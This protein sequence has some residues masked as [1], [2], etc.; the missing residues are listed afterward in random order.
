MTKPAREHYEQAL[1]QCPEVDAEKAPAIAKMRGAILF[2]LAELLTQQGQ[3]Q[4]AMDLYQQS[5]KIDEQIGNVKGKAATLANMAWL[6]WQQGDHEKAR[7]LNLQAAKAFAS[8]RAWLNLVT[9]LGNLGHTGASDAS[10]FLAQA[11][12]L[13]MRVEIPLDEALSLAA[14]LIE[15]LGPGADAV[16]SIAIAGIF[17][18][19][20]R[21][22]DHPQHEEIQEQAL[23]L[24]AACAVVPV[25]S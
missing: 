18:V 20:T 9:V 14:A 21:G 1:A 13:A 15:K 19:Q 17:L 7:M 6:A 23:S 16:P 5:A 25:P 8:I 12:W 4:Q 11:F 24:L 3:I 2:Y 10:V 22:K